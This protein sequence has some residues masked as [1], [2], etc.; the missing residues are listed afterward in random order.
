[1]KKLLVAATVAALVTGYAFSLVWAGRV[2]YAAG[3]HDGMT[4]TALICMMGAGASPH[5]MPSL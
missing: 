1:M 3:L 5:G 2:I 4:A